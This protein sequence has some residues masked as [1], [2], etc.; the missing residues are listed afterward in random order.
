MKTIFREPGCCWEPCS[1]LSAWCGRKNFPCG[2]MRVLRFRW[3]VPCACC[4]RPAFPPGCIPPLPAARNP[5]P[6]FGA[7]GK[8]SLRSCSGCM[9]TWLFRQCWAWRLPGFSGKKF[10]R[11]RNS[12]RAWKIPFGIAA[13]YILASYAMALSFAAAVIPA[14]HAMFSATLLFGIGVLALLR[15]W[16]GIPG[17]VPRPQI[18]V[19][20]F[21]ALSG[22]C[23]F[24]TIHDHLLL[25]GQHEKR[26]RLILE[27]KKGRHAGNHCSSPLSSLPVVF[28]HFLGGSVAKPGRLRQQRRGDVLW[29]EEHQNLL[30]GKS[31]W[32][33]EFF[34]VG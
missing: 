22:I 16:Y 32:M 12:F 29:R 21:L 14:D 23:V 2:F 7:D 10:H 8:L 11:D 4:L 26:V 30:A 15:M 24:S 1:S 3:Q 20:V 17:A 19:A 31:C 9:N 25:F 28:F 27:Q 34:A 33:L 5:F 18:T 13:A 6:V